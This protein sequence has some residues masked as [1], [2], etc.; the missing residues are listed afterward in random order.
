MGGQQVWRVVDVEA[1]Q[2]VEELAKVCDQAKVE[3]FTCSAEE[4][5]PDPEEG[6]EVRCLYS[7]VHL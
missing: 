4:A 2:L 1:V 5:C 3:V 6:E 7:T